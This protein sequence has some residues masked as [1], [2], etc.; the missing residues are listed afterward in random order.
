MIGQILTTYLIIVLA[1]GLI[2]RNIY[3]QIMPA[4]VT[5]CT[6][7]GGECSTMVARK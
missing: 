2:I 6:G 5:S 4:Q 7:C 1:L 3:K